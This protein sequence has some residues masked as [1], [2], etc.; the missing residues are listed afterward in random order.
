MIY[1]F[2]ILSD[3][4][5]YTFTKIFHNPCMLYLFMGVMYLR[6]D[7]RWGEGI[8]FDCCPVN[9]VSM[10]SIFKVVP[11]LNYVFNTL[12]P[13]QDGCHFPDDIFKLIFLNENVWIAVKISLKFVPRCPIN[14]IPAMVQ[15]MAWR[16]PGDKP[17]S[18]PMMVSLP[19][20]LC[21]TWPQWVKPP[22]VPLKFLM[23]TS[24]RARSPSGDRGIGDFIILIA[25][26]WGRQIGLYPANMTG[27]CQGN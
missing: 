18:E 24:Y 17:L 5:Y 6:L 26:K 25:L 1:I 12:R 22:M 27:I 15:I 3:F 21:V 9:L 14:N 23:K 13:R 8:N 11:E 20:H 2:H 7:C 19:T 16:R 4:D 10:E